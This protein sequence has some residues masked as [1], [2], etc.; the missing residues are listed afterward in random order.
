M[1]KQFFS[2]PSRRDLLKGAGLVLAFTF[3]PVRRLFTAEA[4]APGAG[5]RSH[6][7]RYGASKANQEHQRRSAP[8]DC[9]GRPGGE[10]SGARLD[11]DGD[12]RHRVRPSLAHTQPAHRCRQLRQPRP[13]G[14]ELAEHCGDEHEDQHQPQRPS[15]HIHLNGATFPCAWVVL[16]QATLVLRQALHVPPLPSQNEQI[17]M[18]RLPLKQPHNDE[19][20][21]Q[22]AWASTAGTKRFTSRAPKE[23]IFIFS[24]P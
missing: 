12:H 5:T 16:Q 7:P 2:S 20:G 24:P 23:R 9:G 14:P 19:Y 18:Y 13:S 1:N 11:H 21:L 10:H 15:Q 17:R 3:T 8:G 4:A 22:M 6:E